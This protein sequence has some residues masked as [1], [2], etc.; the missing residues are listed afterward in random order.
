MEAP[1]S[2]PSTVR[3]REFHQI[4]ARTL[5]A[6][7]SERET[8]VFMTSLKHLIRARGFAATARKTGLGRAGE[9]PES[10]R[11]GHLTGTTKSPEAD[12]QT[13]FS[14]TSSQRRGWSNHRWTRNRD[15][16]NWTAWWSELNSNMVRFEG[17]T[18]PN[19]GEPKDLCAAAMGSTKVNRG[20]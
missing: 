15:G 19:R 7:L 16:S 11:S 1:Q 12:V 13:R 14:F 5:D 20:G 8:Q 17:R 10:A 6:A 9:A 3:R 4:A 2:T 18:A